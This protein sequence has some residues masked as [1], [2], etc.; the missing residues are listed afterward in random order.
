MCYVGINVNEDNSNLQAAS[1]Q[2]LANVHNIPDPP[3]I[4]L[5][6]LL[7]LGKVSGST[8]CETG[9]KLPSVESAPDASVTA[10]DHGQ[11]QHAS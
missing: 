11:Q 5:L 3:G 9:S 10:G 6:E 7:H 4:F 8:S 1:A 2:T